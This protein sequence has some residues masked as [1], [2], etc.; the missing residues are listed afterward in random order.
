MERKQAFKVFEGTTGIEKCTT[1]GKRK[2]LL[3]QL[4]ICRQA[5]IV[6]QPNKKSGEKYF[7]SDCEG[8]GLLDRVVLLLSLANHPTIESGFTPCIACVAAEFLAYECG[9]HLL[10]ILTDMSA[11]A[12]SLC[13]ASPARKEV[14]GRRGYPGYMYTDLATI[15]ERAGRIEGRRG[16]ITQIPILSMPYDDITHPI[17]NLTPTRRL[18]GANAINHFGRDGASAPAAPA[19]SLKPPTPLLD[20]VNYPVHPK[21]MTSNQLR[22]L[23]NELHQDTIHTVSKTGG[24]L[25]SSLGVIELT[26]ALH[27]VLDAPR[28]KILWDVGQQGVT[29][30]LGEP[31]HDIAPAPQ[32]GRVRPRPTHCGAFDITYLAT[33]PNFVVMALAD[34][35]ELMHMPPAHPSITDLVLCATLAGKDV[36]LLGFGTALQSCMQAADVAD[37]RFCK[38]WMRIGS[39]AWPRSILSSSLKRVP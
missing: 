9:K 36:T 27:H 33:L 24:H 34:E 15:H 8:N 38:P 10:V 19:V 22:Q 3:S 18:V 2:Y 29:K 28:D 4:P 39:D 6:Q 32:S 14:P 16:S 7:K 1:R 31:I 30:S 5:G 37:A 21:N 11:Y 17:P 23:A 20:T 12:D 35:A 26:V 25:G 13:E